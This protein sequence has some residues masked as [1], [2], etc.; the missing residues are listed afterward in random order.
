VAG[1]AF[2]DRAR[3]QAGRIHV[4]SRHSHRIDLYALT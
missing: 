2:G 3:A 4:Q 1:A